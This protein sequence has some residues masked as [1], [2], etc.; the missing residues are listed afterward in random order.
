M[1]T[2]ARRRAAAAVAHLHRADPR[3]GPRA[4]RPSSCSR[5]G[6]LLA[7]VPHSRPVSVFATSYDDDVSPS[8]T[9]WLPSRYEG[10]TGITGVLHTACRDA[11]IGSASLWAAVPTYVPSAPSPK[12]ALALVERAVE[13]TRPPGSAP[14]SS[15]SPRAS[16]ERQVDELVDRRRGDPRLRRASSRSASTA[17][18]PTRSATRTAWSTRSSAS[19]ASNP[20]SPTPSVL[21]I[22]SVRRHQVRQNERRSRLGPPGS[23]AAHGGV[24]GPGAGLLEQAGQAQHH[25]VGVAAA[26]DLQA[27]GQARRT[28]GRPAPSTPGSSTG[29]PA[30]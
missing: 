27:D 24:A 19:C 5:F 3:R 6:A 30:W 12:A 4:R 20:S 8:L 13:L 14:P 10:P 23:A 18:R 25:V 2:L 16:Y 28:P 7:E 1:I 9:T 29:W 17:A 15:R 22:V 21:A 11:G 26:H